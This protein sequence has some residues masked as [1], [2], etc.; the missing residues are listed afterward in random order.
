M[1]AA[2]RSRLIAQKVAL[3]AGERSRQQERAAPACSTDSLQIV[4]KRIN[5][6]HRCM[7]ELQRR[8]RRMHVSASDASQSHCCRNRAWRHLLP[9]A[10]PACEHLCPC[11]PR[12]LLLPARTPFT[13]HIWY[14][15]RCPY[16][17]VGKACEVDALSACR[18]TPDGPGKLGRA[19]AG[20]GEGV[21]HSCFW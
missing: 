1:W 18:I 3:N 19:C 4:Y 8:Y 2:G 12:P 13:R 16:G 7:Q 10:M 21:S 9:A 20:L 6:F 17:R 5:M 14:A 15:C 11:N